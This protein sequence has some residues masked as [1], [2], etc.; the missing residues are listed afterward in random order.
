[1]KNPFDRILEV[2]K[3]YKYVNDK[4]LENFRPNADYSLDFLQTRGH[5]LEA[6][7]EA[8]KYAKTYVEAEKDSIPDPPWDVSNTKG[9]K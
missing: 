5:K 1:M 3:D 2:Y 9:L 4:L 6:S 8:V 7:I